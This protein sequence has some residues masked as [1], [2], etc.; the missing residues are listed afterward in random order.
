[1]LRVHSLLHGEAARQI[2]TLLLVT[3]RTHTPHLLLERLLLLLLH[4]VVVLLG[5]ITEARVW[6]GRVNLSHVFMLPL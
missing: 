3:Q 2:I 4:L 1:M 6:I 5:A